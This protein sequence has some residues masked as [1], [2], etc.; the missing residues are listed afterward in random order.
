[1]R[2]PRDR[3]RYCFAAESG[4][5]RGLRRPSRRVSSCSTGSSGPRPRGAARPRPACAN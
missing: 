4:G 3:T 5:E 1:M 2:L